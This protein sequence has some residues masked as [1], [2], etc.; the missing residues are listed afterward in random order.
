MD[1]VARSAPEGYTLVLA[2]FAHAANS[3]LQSKLPYDSDQA[4]CS[5]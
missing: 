1:L 3:T 5:S 4:F 2:T